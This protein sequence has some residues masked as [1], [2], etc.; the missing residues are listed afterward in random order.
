MHGSDV[1]PGDPSP[2]PWSGHAPV[3]PWPS[4]PVP[5]GTPVP[6]DAAG[7][8]GLRPRT[9]VVAGAL[10][11]AVLL[12]GWAASAPGGEPDDGAPAGSATSYAVSAT[13]PRT[14][15]PVGFDP[16]RPEIHYV[17]R[18]DGGPPDGDAIIAEAFAEASAA[19]GFGFVLD[20][21]TTQGPVD[22]VP[23]LWAEQSSPVVVSWSTEAEEPD[24]AGEVWGLASSDQAPSL[25]GGEAY[26]S[27]QVVLDSTDLLP[28]LDRRGGRARVRAVVMHEVGHLLGLDHVEDRTQLMYEY[29]LPGVDAYGAGDLAGLAALGT[30]RCPTS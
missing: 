19:T 21:H 20:G 26:R 1:L 28:E 15:A 22:R 23:L 9:W 14:G 29:S 12:A 5:P 7:P 10:C 8:G 18:P 2:A 4:A 24:L 27:G 30:A 6:P 16:C 17:V 25:H 11:G 13:D 3:Q